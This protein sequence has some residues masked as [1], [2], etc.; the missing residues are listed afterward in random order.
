MEKLFNQN[1]NFFFLPVFFIDFET[2]K[3]Q[4]ESDIVKFKT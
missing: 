3:D 1:K 2:V 4:T